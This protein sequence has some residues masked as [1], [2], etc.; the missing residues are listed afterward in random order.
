MACSIALTR[1]PG[2]ENRNKKA[3]GGVFVKFAFCQ[4]TW[5]Q[6]K[7]GPPL[8]GACLTLG[9]RTCAQR[10]QTRPPWIAYE[11]PPAPICLRV[12]QTGVVPSR[13][14]TLGLLFCPGLYTFWACLRVRPAV[15]MEPGHHWPSAHMHVVEGLGFPKTPARSSLHEQWGQS[16]ER[17][18]PR[19]GVFPAS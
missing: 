14:L 4:Q 9:G 19:I 7:D 11:Q 15:S 16:S 13:V 3:Q 1:S 8:A 2:A 10:G 12:R 5:N 18:H 6:P 17:E